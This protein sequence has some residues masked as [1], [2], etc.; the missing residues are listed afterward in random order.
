MATTAD[1]RNGLTIEFKNDIYQVIEFQHVKPGKGGAFVRTKLKNVVNGRVLEQTFRSGETIDIVRLEAKKMQFLYIE[2]DYYVFMDQ[3]TFEQIHLSEKQIGDDKYFLKEGEI[4]DVLFHGDT[5]LSM[6]LPFFI[7]YTVVE[8]EPGV[9]GDTA[10]GGATK[11]AKIETGAT[12][13]V[14]LF[15]EQGDKIRVDT[16]TRTYMERVKE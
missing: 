14:P 7:V 13:Q 4:V 11:P 12:I 3:E 8:T 6:T 1:L 15:V 2:N 10:Q 9:R 16:R 5:P